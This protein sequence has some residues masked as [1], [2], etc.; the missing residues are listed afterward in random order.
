MRFGYCINMLASP[1][2]DGSGRENIGMIAALGFDYVELPLAQMM[3]YDLSDFKKLF[4]EPLTASGLTCRC[5]NNFLPA[6]IRLTGEHADLPAAIQYADRAMER[7]SM[8]GAGKIVFGSSG[9]RNYPLGFS[10]KAAMEQIKAFLT[11]LSPLAQKYQITIVLEHL[12]RSESNL[13]NSLSEGTRLR[14]ELQLPCLENLLD[15][16]HFSLSGESTRDILEAGS[17]L[18]HIHAART[19]NRSLPSAGD[20]FDWHKLFSTL[21]D[22]DYDQDISIEAYAPVQD[23]SEHIRKSLAFLRSL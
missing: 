9:A 21:Q 10:R 22:I 3:A 18:F 14:Q 1:D 15:T 17:H 16:Y 2:S 19:L 11:E 8:L 23:R 6:S 12:N 5:C 7:A 4:L 13:I 20:E